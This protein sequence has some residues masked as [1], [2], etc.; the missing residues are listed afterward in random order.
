MA[1]SPSFNISPDTLS[2][3]T[4]LFFPIALTLLLII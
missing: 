3:P 1:S 4:D 2:G